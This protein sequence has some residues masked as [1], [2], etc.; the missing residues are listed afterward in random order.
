MNVNDKISKEKKVLANLKLE[1]KNIFGRLGNSFHEARLT[2]PDSLILKE[3]K[4][5]EDSI[6][7][8]K[9][10]MDELKEL[11][12]AVEYGEKSMEQ[13]NVKIKELKKIQNSVIKKIGIEVYS[14]IGAIELGHQSVRDIYDTLQ[15]A[16]SQSEAL[17]TALYKYENSVDN[18]KFFDKIA[19]PFKVKKIKHDLKNSNKNIFE[20]FNDLG[21]AYVLIPELLDRD[22]PVSLQ[23][24]VAE[25]KDNLQRIEKEYKSLEKTLG[26]IGQNSEKI[27]E[28]SR[29]VKL[30]TL[31]SQL[32]KDIIGVQNNITSKLEELGDAVYAEFGTESDN[33]DVKAKLE[34]C[35]NKLLEIKESEERLVYLDNEAELIELNKEIK[36][37]EASISRED[38]HIKV[39]KKNIAKHKKELTTSLKNKETL[40]QWFDANSKSSEV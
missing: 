22:E 24:I 19:Q 16:E 17:E 37:R 31:Y 26:M 23:S 20:L 27:K 28:G 14:T 6:P 29:G 30:K 33:S 15:A 9:S 38:E 4:E 8:I 7:G 3:L 11:S 39:C 36:E 34:I 12:S 35:S 13:S 2:I 32:E 1:L 25:Y 5:L 21:D 10:K 40:N 18:K